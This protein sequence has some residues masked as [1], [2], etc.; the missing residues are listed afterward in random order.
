[1]DFQSETVFDSLRTGATGSSNSGAR[2]PVSR[3]S[4]MNHP[5]EVRKPKLVDLQ[6][7]LQT[8]SFSGSQVSA[9]GK[10]CIAEEE[11]L[12]TPFVRTLQITERMISPRL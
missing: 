3:R 12:S 6:E 10:H 4:L 11:I 5:A 9:N 7:L 8:G 2:G 1:M